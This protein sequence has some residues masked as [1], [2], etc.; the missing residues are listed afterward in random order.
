[1]PLHLARLSRRSFLAQGAVAVAGLATM[2]Y[3][4]GA[5]REANSNQ[6][7]LLSDTHIP[8]MPEVTARGTNMTSNLNQVVREVTALAEKPAAVIV[9][10]DCAHLKGLP[11]DYANF[12]QCIAPFSQAGLPVHITMGNHDDRTPLFNTLKFQKPE[13]PLLESKHVSIVE[14]PHANWF[15]LDS[16]TKTD[17]VTG[18]LGADQRAWLAKALGSRSDKPALVM[19]HHNPQFEPPAEGQAW[20]GIRDT[21][22]FMDILGSFKHVK[23]FIFGHSHDWSIK[24]RGNLQLVNLPPVAYVFTAG[25]P[26]GWVL[27]DV[28]ESRL[29][30]TLRT[31]DPR[32][33]QHGE[34]VE[35]AW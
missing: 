17:V 2:P 22:E 27:A 16:L 3:V 4:F 29:T 8:S 13:R 6:L 24:K 9:N 1:M 5:E 20:G 7:A 10:G 30:L 19:A 14:T 23:A 12:S 32:H 28:G 25:K 11:A 18:E 21:A 35:L 34:R 15:L 33:Q 26:N 31:I